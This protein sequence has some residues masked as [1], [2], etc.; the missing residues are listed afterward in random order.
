M[1]SVQPMIGFRGVSKTYGENCV[2]DHVDLSIGKGEFVTL[3]GRSGCGKTTLLKMINA[4]IRP[5]Q[6]SVW[7]DGR[8]VSQ[9][10]QIM[11]RRNIGYVIQNVGLFLSLIHI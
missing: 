10:D 11:L 7:V 8:D 5:D 2:L 9:V 3:I 6:G 1:N 4:L